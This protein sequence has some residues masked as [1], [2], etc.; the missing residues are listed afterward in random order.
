MKT[1]K[2]SYDAVVVGG[3]LAGLTAAIY[4]AKAEKSVILL[5]KAA[6]LGGYAQTTEKN[7]ALFNFGPH[8]M[9]EGGAALQ[10]LAEMDCLPPGGYAK[11]TNS[12]LIGI[13]QGEI[14]H[15]PTD[16][17]DDEN[18]EWVNLMGGLQNIDVEAINGIS[19]RQW[20]EEKIKH[21]R[22]KEFFYGMCRQWAYCDDSTVL[23][24]GYVIRQGQLAGNGV[25]YVEKGWQT[26]VQIL[27]EKAVQLGVEIQTNCKVE[28]VYH[29][30]GV[31]HGVNFADGTNI[32][33]SNVVIALGP[34]EAS[35]LVPGSDEMSL[36]SWK[37]Q[38]RP[39]YAACLDVAL[40]QLPRSDQVFAIGLDQPFYFGVH[41]LS[42]SLSNN[43]SHVLHVLKYNDDKVKTDAK[44]DK[45]EL[46]ELL[47]LLQPGWEQEV[48]ATRFL[49]KILVANDTHT[50]AH[51]GAGSAPHPSVPEIKGL[52]VAGDWVGQEGRLADCSMASAKLA[53]EQILAQ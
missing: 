3:G 7:G 26:V 34:N 47:E 45:K 35:R 17:T 52:Y 53:T 2:N 18:Q 9:Y 21:S 20:T 50:A 40:K 12:G 43:G 46:M 32:S 29:Q 5:E 11:K 14:V 28:H 42:V 24:A 33:T 8:A 15:I 1:Q 36:G 13:K 4:L 38:S 10:I 25:R 37:E 27:A 39:L 31:V 23:S 22:V 19:I 51:N 44:M 30:D 6:Q 16:L 49:P 48:V 41:S